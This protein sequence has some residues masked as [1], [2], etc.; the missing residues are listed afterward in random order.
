MTFNSTNQA[1]P[2]PPLL[3]LLKPLSIFS[4][5]IMFIV[6]FLLTHIEVAIAHNNVVVIPLAGDDVIVEVPTE[7]TPT[8][9]IAN[10][11]T[12]QSDYTIGSLTA[13]D[14]ITKLE[15]QRMDDNIERNWHDAWDYCADLALDTHDDWRLPAATELQSIADYSST[16]KPYIDPVAFTNTN[17][18]A[19]YWSATMEASNSSRAWAAIGGFVGT[20]STT[21]LGF[22]RCVR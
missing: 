16:T 1:K 8:T 21:S 17:S 6:L 4:K 19:F 2:L 15:W 5:R 22:V 7:L 3:S 10:V 9:P 13:V 20:A 12:S 18:D 11:D 14:N